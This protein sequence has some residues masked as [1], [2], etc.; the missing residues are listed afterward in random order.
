VIATASGGTHALVIIVGVVIIGRLGY[1]VSKSRGRRQ[2]TGSAPDGSAVDRRPRPAVS[3][4]APEGE[5]RKPLTVGEVVEDPIPD[6]SDLTVMY[7][8]KKAVDELSLQIARGEI[9]GLLGPNG[10]GKTSTLSAVEG[11]LRPRSGKVLLDA[12][13]I[14]HDPITA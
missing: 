3:S 1:A 14:A 9:F 5:A 8:P 6:I 2:S 13:D 12:I 10:A 11:L 7:G 4:E